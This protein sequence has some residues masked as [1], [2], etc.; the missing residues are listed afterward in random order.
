MPS[1]DP[2][3]IQ[4]LR[5]YRLALIAREEDQTKRLAASWFQLEKSLS[6]DMLLLGLQ[7][8]EEQA[9]GSI[10]TEQLLRRMD[11]YKKLDNQM[12]SQILKYAKTT[13]TNDIE[14][15]Q[16]SYGISAI[17]SASEAIRLTA[18]LGVKF[19][20]LPVDAIE[21][22]VGYLGDGTPLYRLLKEA[23]P[24]SLN[25]VVNAFLEGA[26]KGLNPNTIAFNA[27]RALGIGL[28]RITLI[29]RTE[30]LRVSR[31][32]SS[33]QYRDSGLQGYMRRVATKDSAV[34]MACL[35]LDGQI[36]P[37]DQELDDHPRGRCVAVFQIKGSPVVQWEK[38]ADWFVKQEESLQR[39]MMGNDKFEAWKD[40]TFELKDIAK[41]Q[42]SKIWGDSPRV[43]TL[44]ELVQ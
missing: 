21:T 24:E 19:D 2:E 16:L 18:G 15:E 38:G 34:C 42:E 39:Q 22:Y 25:G 1:N 41:I 37:L 30:Q 4:H 35:M 7:I 31:N 13:A 29:A 6:D 10:I 20:R 9:K 17:Q 14:K 3:V 32:V 26:S 44:K 11:R 28:E 27:S 8:Q 36:I 40:G 12:K 23:Y 43:A 33:Q 5:Q